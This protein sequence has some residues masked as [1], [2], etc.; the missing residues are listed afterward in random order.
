MDMATATAES[1]NVWFAQLIA[2]VGPEKVQEV[3]KKMGVVSYAYNSY[4]SVP[5]VCSMISGP[6][7]SKCAR[8]FASLLYWSG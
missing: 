6:V 5:A 4:V 1:V 7:V 3:A 2:D 8:Q